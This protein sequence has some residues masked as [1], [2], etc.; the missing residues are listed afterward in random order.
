MAIEKQVLDADLVIGGV[1]VAGAMAQKLLNEQLVKE[2]RA[3]PALFDVA[4]ER[5]GCCA[6]STA[7]V[8]SDAGG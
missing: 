5:G 7:T 8:H 3:D 2:M 1:L 4:I 6:T